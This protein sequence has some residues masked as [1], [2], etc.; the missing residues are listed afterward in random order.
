[1]KL[2]ENEINEIFSQISKNSRDLT[3]PGYPYGLIDADRFA[4]ISEEEAKGYKVMFLS[5]IAKNNKADSFA[6]VHAIDAHD[7]L[8]ELVA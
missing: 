5:Q 8:N 1:V 3:F 2:K 7:I 6:S 4:R